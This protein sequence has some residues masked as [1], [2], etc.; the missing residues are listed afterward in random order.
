M[1]RRFQFHD[2]PITL[3]GGCR[4]VWREEGRSQFLTKGFGGAAGIHIFDADF[5]LSLPRGE[6]V[7]GLEEKSQVSCENVSL[8]VALPPLAKAEMVY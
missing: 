1:R 4:R 7:Q 2:G 8:D 6:V 5:S 3:Y